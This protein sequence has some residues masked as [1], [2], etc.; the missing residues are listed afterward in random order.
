MR[1]YKKS[2]VH[3]LSWTIRGYPNDEFSLDF[4]GILQEYDLTAKDEISTDFLEIL[5]Q[6]KI[7]I[8]AKDTGQVLND[9][10]IL[11]FLLSKL[12]CMASFRYDDKFYVYNYEI[13]YEIFQMTEFVIEN[14]LYPVFQLDLA[15]MKTEMQGIVDLEGQI[16]FLRKKRKKLFKPDKY[17]TNFT[18][19]ME[20]RTEYNDDKWVQAVIKNLIID[21]HFVTFYLS[22]FKHKNLEKGNF[23]KEM[24]PSW[25]N[26]SRKKKLIKFCDEELKKLQLNALNSNK[27]ITNNASIDDHQTRKYEDIIFKDGNEGLFYFIEEKY[28]GEK[29]NAFFSYLYHFFSSNEFLLKNLKSSLDYNRFLIENKFIDKFSKVIQITTDNAEEQDRMFK[30]YKKLQSHF[31]KTQE[32]EDNEGNLKE[33]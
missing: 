26:Y 9:K 21:K 13:F 11:Q 30:I 27:S 7:Y 20:E 29:N 8:E 31:I 1:K 4:I 2:F 14:D 17:L 19:Y 33:I 28:D 16:K 22:T 18:H 5:I 6:K 23:Y 12:G 3:Y 15:D 24:F 25:S 32:R 10:S